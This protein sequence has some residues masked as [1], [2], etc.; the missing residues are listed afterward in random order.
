M[1]PEVTTPAITWW[2]I[3][4]A[5]GGTIIGGGISYCLQRMNLSAA[6]KQR[7][8]DRRQIREAL[9]YSLLFKLITIVSRL[10]HIRNSIKEMFDEAKTAG[11]VGEPWNIMRPIVP[12][13][14]SIN[15]K[16]EEMALVLSLSDKVFNEIASL[17]EIHN[18]TI[19]VLELY[20][21]KRNAL[22]EHFG[23]EM[24]GNIGTTTLT[25]EQAEWLGPRSVEL[26][27]VAKS[28]LD[29]IERDADAA[30]ASLKD[31]H[32][33]FEKGLGLKKKLEFV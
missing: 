7:E 21:S 19:A 8:E 4:S 10:H 26:N 17:D 11:F 33:V 12:I 27:E 23:A 9:A 31:L 14:N 28:I 29:R 13:P 20:S 32:G 22:F 16:A 30:V 3:A 18:S 6:K 2:A 5:F 1:G 24:S 15:F 25:R